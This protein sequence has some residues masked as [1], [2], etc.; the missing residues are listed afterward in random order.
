MVN[1]TTSDNYY[2]VLKKG[3][4]EEKNGV[5]HKGISG[6]IEQLC[7]SHQKNTVK[8]KERDSM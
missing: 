1:T 8:K 7:L 2:A 4:I 3:I 6:M 5:D